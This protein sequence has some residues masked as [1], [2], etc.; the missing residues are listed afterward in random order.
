M[1]KL[2]IVDLEKNY[3]NTLKNCSY[4]CVNRGIL[5]F[6][7]SKQIPYDLN[8]NKKNLKKNKR[9]LIYFFLDLKKKFEKKTNDINSYELE[10]FNLRN[11]KYDYLD[12]ILI[13]YELKKKV[14]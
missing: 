5:N 4:I 11:D 6:Q 2:V 14:T 10:I 8:H 12:K 3:H 1:E 13:F 7:N 9:D